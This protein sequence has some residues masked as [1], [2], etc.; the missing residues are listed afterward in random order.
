MLHRFR[1]PWS[2]RRAER[3][4]GAL[5]S[6][7]LVLIGAM[8]VFVMVKAWPSFAHNGLGWFGSGGSVDDQLTQI[9]NS[10]ADPAKWDYTIRAWPLLYATLLTTG[11]AVIFGMIIAVLAAA[12]IVEFAPEPVRRVLEPV[13]RLLAAVP[14]VIYGLIGILVIV[15]WVGNHLIST[16]RKESVAGIIQLNGTSLA[17]AVLILTIMIVPIMIAIVVDALRAVPRGWREGAVALGVNRWRALWTVSLRASRPALVA[18]AVLATARALGE[19]IMLSMV[20][21]SVGWGPNPLDGMTFWFEPL[22]PLAATIVDNAEGLSVKP[23]GQTIYAFAAVLLVSSFFLSLAGSAA[24]Q[25][26]KKYGVR[27]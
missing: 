23:F 4:L 3:V 8:V 11:L 21:G 24:K 17:V 6:L 16:E 10:P 12:F 1:Q 22:R 27:V 9:F 19:A 7:L 26:L 13:V 2:D 14:S 15:P 20:S 5:S 25:P 18:A